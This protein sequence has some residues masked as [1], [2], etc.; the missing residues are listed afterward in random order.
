VLPA[1]VSSNQVSS[2]GTDFWLAF[3]PNAGETM[4][5]NPTRTFIYITAD[6]ASNVVVRMPA[7]GLSFDEAGNSF[8][9]DKVLNIPAGESIQVE[10]PYENSIIEPTGEVD[11]EGKQY[12][13]EA[14]SP[15]GIQITSDNPVSVYALNSLKYSADATLVYPYEALGDRTF[16]MTQGE[17]DPD[18]KSRSNAQE[19]IIVATEDNTEV[20]ITL[21]A[22]TIGGATAGQTITTSLNA[23]ETYQIQSLGDLTGTFVD[24]KCKPVAV[25][26]GNCFT[27]V[28]SGASYRDALY[29][30]NLP[31]IR[32]G[33]R[34]IIAP[35]LTRTKSDSY[36]ILA[37]ADNTEIS[38]N[39]SEG[40]R[41]ITLNLGEY[42]FEELPIVDG[43]GY[44]IE[45]SQ[46][47]MLA[48]FSNSN[49]YDGVT[50]SDPFMDMVPSIEQSINEIVF[51]V[52][53]G[54]SVNTYYINIITLTEN[55]DNITL[56]GA[57]I[58]D[59]FVPNA[60]YGN[61]AYSIARFSI[62]QGNHILQSDKKGF[63]A[64]VYGYESR[65]S[66]GYIA[67]ASAREINL[68]FDLT[69]DDTRYNH[70]DFKDTVCY[71]D[72]LEF[73]ALERPDVE[74]Y[75]WVFNE[76][77]T[78]WGDT[79]VFPVDYIGEINIQLIGARITDCGTHSDTL[80]KTIG[81][82]DLP[83]IDFEMT[84]TVCH[85]DKPAVNVIPEGGVFS[86]NEDEF[87]D[88]DTYINSI[89][90]DTGKYVFNY[91][92]T[93]EYMCSATLSDSVYVRP[94]PEAEI[95]YVNAG[96]TNSIDVTLDAGVGYD[97][98]SWN[99]G[100]STQTII[101]KQS[102]DYSVTV[103][104]GGCE[105]ADTI[106][107]PIIPHMYISEDDTI[108]LGD[109][110]SI[111]ARTNGFDIWT[112]NGKEF[113]RSD[114][115]Y[116][117]PDSSADYVA[118]SWYVADDHLINEDFENGNTGFRS[119]YIYS[120]NGC[121]QRQYMIIDDSKNAAPLYF[122]SMPDHTTGTGNMMVVDGGSRTGDAVFEDTVNVVAGEKYSFS[123]WMA[124]IHLQYQNPPYLRFTV[125]DEPLGVLDADSL[126]VWRQ[127]Y[128]IWEA[129]VSGEVI[130]RIENE[131]PEPQGNDFVLDDIQFSK[132][133]AELIDSVHIEVQQPFE[134][135]LGNDTL[136][137][138]NDTIV[139]E[140]E[141]GDSYLWNTSDTSRTISITESGDYSVVVQR[142][143]CFDTASVS[144]SF[145]PLPDVQM[146]L[147]DTICHNEEP[148]V[149]VTPKG[150][151][152]S[153]NEEEF[154]DFDTYINSI[155][156]DT[157][158]SVFN[159]SF[160]D[161]YMCSATVSDSVY[162][163]PMP[164]AKIDYIDSGR[165][166][167]IDV[168]LD[169]GIGYDTYSWNT[170]ETTQKIV[171]KKSD[172]Y[173][174]TVSVKG[175]EGVDT[176]FVPIIPYM[177]IS[178]DDTICRGDTASIAARTN[179]FNIWTKNGKEFSLSDT[180][181]FTPD[182]S[183]DYV[184][185]SWY[186]AEDHLLNMDFENGNTGFRSDYLYSTSGCSYRQYMVID[187][188]KD[189]APRY[190]FSMADHTT[191]AGNMMVVDGGSRKGDAVF[192]DTVNV[193]A[194]EKYS[195][196]VWMASIHLQY[197][198]PPYLRFMVNDEPL[199]VLDADSLP[200]WRQ[201]YTIWEADVSG[202]VIVRIEN[203][204]TESQGNDFVLDDI[205]F[206]KIEAELIDTVHIEVQQPFEVSL[207]NDT[208]ACINDTIVLESEIG[209]SYLWNTSDTSRTISITESG[210]YSV[211]VQ[212]QLCYDTASVSASFTP[213]PD[214]QLTLTDTIC[215]GDTPD[216]QVNLADGYFTNDTTEYTDFPFD[217][218][219]RGNNIF[220]YTAKD[221]NNCTNMATDTVHVRELPSITIDYKDEGTGDSVLVVLD[222]G[223]NYTMYDWNNGSDEQI[224]VATQA[225]YYWVEISDNGC[226]G[227]DTVYVPII[228]Y[229]Y[230]SEN[231][232]ICQ[233][234]SSN[235][236]A[237]T[238]G[239]FSWTIDET[240][241][242]NKDTLDIT[243]EETTNYIAHSQFVDY[244]YLLNEN[245]EG[246]APSY[247][248]D[249][250]FVEEGNITRGEFSVQEDANNASPSYFFNLNDHTT[251]NGKMM[252]VDGDT[253][254]GS[255]IFEDTV[256]VEAGRKY[257]FSVW[258]SSIH[259]DYENP[260]YLQF[261]IEDEMLGF[262]DADSIPRWKQFYTIWKANTSG[263]VAVRIENRN[264]LWNGNDFALDDIQFSEISL[265]LR[266]TVHIKV[267]Q[268]FELA[269]GDDEDICPTDSI[270]LDA[271]IGESYLWNTGDTSRQ[272][273]AD[274]LNSY[275]VTVSRGVC[276]ETDTIDI[277]LIPMLDPAVDFTAT[278]TAVCDG[279][280]IT[281]TVSTEENLGDEPEFIWYVN[282]VIKQ[283]GREFSSQNLTDSAIVRLDALSSEGCISDDTVD[284]S[285]NIRIFPLLTPY[286]EIS[287]DT[288]SVCEGDTISFEIDT[289]SNQGENPTYQ[290]FVNDV[291]VSTDSLFQSHEFNTGD[292]VSF[293][294]TSTEECLT[295]ENATDELI[296]Q[297][298]QYPEYDLGNDT[299]LCPYEKIR[300]QSP[301]S[302]DY[303]WNDG[304]DSYSRYISNPGGSYSVSVTSTKGCITIDSIKI[305][306]YDTLA[307][308]ITGD[309]IIYENSTIELET[310]VPFS[311]YLWRFGQTTQSIKA[312]LVQNTDFWV[313]VTDENNCTDT[314]YK[315][316]EVLPRPIINISD[317][318]FCEGESRT[319]TVE[320]DFDEYDWKG[321]NSDDKSLTI[322]ESGT[323][324]VEGKLNGE[325]PLSVYDTII[326]TKKPLPVFEITDPPL[327]CEGDSK[328][329]GTESLEDHS[330]RWSSGQRSSMITIKNAGEYILKVTLN[331]C[332][333]S[334]TAT[335]RVF[336][337]PETPYTPDYSLCYY[338]SL[339]VIHA[340]SDSVYWY[341]D[342]DLTTL[343]DT[344][345]VFN[346]ADNFPNGINIDDTLDLYTQA[347]GKACD[348]RVHHTRII[349]RDTA[350]SLKIH[351][352][353]T[354]YC[355][356]EYDV[357][358]MLS[359]YID[360]L[361]WY[362]EGAKISKYDGANIYVD[363]R[364]EGTPF[365]SAK[366]VDFQGCW[367]YDTI[368]FTIL[369]R[370]EAVMKFN[371]N[372]G[373]GYFENISENPVEDSVRYYWKYLGSNGWVEAGEKD[374]ITQYTR[375]WHG[376]GLKAVNS[377]GC[378]S[379]DNRDFY[380]ELPYNLMVPNAFAPNHSAHLVSHFKAMG[381][382][383]KIFKMWIY[384]NWGNT[385]WYTDKLTED[386]QPL[387]FW[388]GTY[389]GTEMKPDCYIWKIEAV[390]I[391]DEEWDGQEQ[392]DGSFKKTGPLMLIR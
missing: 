131:N 268:A 191:G 163:R 36:K 213:L 389:E 145:N 97:S 216:V 315:L 130:V 65:E 215:L 231:D 391:N 270:L 387:E 263:K 374:T 384:D 89:E 80:Y 24:S 293:E 378:S 219:H 240:D 351:A 110:A 35:Y 210:D 181:Y 359:A 171:A 248:S 303:V 217:L 366:T 324:I 311:E 38:I 242:S 101:A 301:A 142:Q 365:V 369:P 77:D 137:C 192:E 234:D 335:A 202:E 276:T 254:S 100:E 150:G 126:P 174:V 316:V 119:D 172:N 325:P 175:C 159:Y 373:K 103:S 117:T 239:F 135:S 9:A 290:W 87:S 88:F 243:P 63:L 338:D 43:F 33:R 302:L 3:M 380:V 214:V 350:T 190:F 236:A 299:T 275:A 188:S 312:T 376:A 144:V 64:N 154:A 297:V 238:N 258:M 309:D 232:T 143:L 326:A 221:T 274:T 194:G 59:R 148:A 256:L 282:D 11:V 116:F 179:G 66:Y 54:A 106:F 267:D 32:Y 22:E 286:V 320:P 6:V 327:F 209:D 226:P 5:G 247:R 10:I 46:P 153:F 269:L 304:F 241:F 26:G 295:A 53:E 177:H 28:P 253:A 81:I 278:D 348:S 195:F 134:V 197:Q 341:A 342:Q 72:T 108:C 313:Y 29:E 388:D 233:G 187:D 74:I 255:V 15:R 96:G 44:S 20:D 76:T 115:V 31:S 4:D 184:V 260:P 78:V 244:D 281:F 329:I 99:T 229:L 21:A 23:G 170:G 328:T 50:N 173:S 372:D 158:K 344:G 45:A 98:Y 183:A 82:S 354:V 334:D 95:N 371:L 132:I 176:V 55:V 168:T 392:E 94:M 27:G 355:E 161:E 339:P 223:D 107:V 353:S 364:E 308:E 58:G 169:A 128:T 377:L 323:Y 118:H 90:L 284:A 264:T 1:Q 261:T 122:F 336:E 249:Y 151:I 156:L 306:F 285:Q 178:P 346:I 125:N 62:D 383:L 8:S 206:S 93:N 361:E 127:F 47:I 91:S 314:A 367:Y 307:F 185:H 92:F 83:S 235:I 25:F 67:G 165:N 56:D 84:D 147:T 70:L 381:T 69:W 104:V 310:S 102:S 368:N 305:E 13:P 152:F 280:E 113:S 250:H 79:A 225:G 279:T 86:Y 182:S 228:P 146:T 262:I 317:V 129:D 68:D 208:L 17:K 322:S 288:L 227:F 331:G 363:F 382:N 121:S 230:V 136:A 37:L 386:G 42:S 167:S 251:G 220:T 34:Y 73:S 60:I 291:P 30:Q 51:N 49:Q 292:K 319:L 385:V 207:G 298:N 204:N 52:F 343:I 283:Q 196:S 166:D 160:T 352:D 124:S 140:S 186:I 257:I 356:G 272:I 14:V 41:T 75:K 289:I 245:F 133:E 162:V 199:G 112:K 12:F 357:P 296:V 362:Q 123:V 203:E 266:D 390:F 40:V 19:M 212:R 265:E 109:T 120:T 155:E 105:G 189:A 300:I 71:A 218:I 294:I 273:Y 57:P 16:A 198:N 114:T 211:V 180:V 193:V 345:N 318:S 370:P 330:Y 7:Q 333:A 271:G 277:G 85:N 340:T 259:I 48:H 111:A 321:M 246:D 332:S 337:L 349:R 347:K 252:V 39:T 237:R 375:G 18:G 200:V 379:I 201:F 222:A 157:G 358:I 205:Q 141:I 139:L 224:I 138:V 149:S 287:A 360:S 61:D 2:K 164:E